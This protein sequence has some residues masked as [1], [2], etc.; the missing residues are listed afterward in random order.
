M[1]LIRAEHLGFT[2]TR[3]GMTP[4][5]RRTLAVIL[6]KYR[7]WSI[8]HGDCVGADA[9]L[10][11]LARELGFG[12]DLIWVHPPEDD[13][14]RAYCEAPPG[15]IFRPRPY[16]ERDCDIAAASVRLVAAPAEA[17]EQPRGGVWYTVRHA[18]KLG[19]P[20]KIILPSG[21][22]RREGWWK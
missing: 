16:S 3:R 6:R 11:C 18:R 1:E 9:E 7:G 19:R 10:H 22:V 14:Y 15:R 5:Q 13:R 17:G 12:D 2:G 4:E 20:V 21:K 8:S